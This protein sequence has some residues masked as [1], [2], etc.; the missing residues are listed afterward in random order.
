MSQE[1]N[2]NSFSK[3]SKSNLISSGRFS[4]TVQRKGGENR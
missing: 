2:R 1:E 3:E 4:R